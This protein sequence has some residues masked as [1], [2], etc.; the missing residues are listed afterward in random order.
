MD[1]SYHIVLRTNMRELGGTGILLAVEAIQPRKCV[2]KKDFI[3]RQQISRSNKVISF[4][5]QN[6]T[7]GTNHNLCVVKKVHYF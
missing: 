2:I 7:S 4:R 3:S 6:E 5:Q 1:L